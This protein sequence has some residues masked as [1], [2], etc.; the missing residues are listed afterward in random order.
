MV[1][2]PSLAYMPPFSQVSID[3]RRF[4]DIV[5]QTVADVR[6]HF[7]CLMEIPLCRWEECPKSSFV[8]GE[9][10]LATSENSGRTQQTKT[11]GG[12]SGRKQRANTAGENSG[13]VPRAKTNTCG[14]ICSF[15][16]A[17]FH[18]VLYP[19]LVYIHPFRRFSLMSAEFRISFYRLSQ[20]FVFIS[21][22]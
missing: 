7:I 15:D 2:Y 10:P 20:M 6:V 4:P 13:R 17:G 5:L 16:V 18:L 12:H 8:V 14:P 22:A 3:V 1:S 19:F 9:I 11:T 21:F